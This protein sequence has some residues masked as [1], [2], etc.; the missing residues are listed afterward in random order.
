ML[1]CIQCVLYQNIIIELTQVL[2]LLLLSSKTMHNW[3]VIC[4]RSRYITGVLSVQEADT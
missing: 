2:P 3:G 1:I 4:A